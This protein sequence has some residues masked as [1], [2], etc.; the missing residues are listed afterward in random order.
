[1]HQ[2]QLTKSSRSEACLRQAYRFQKL[3]FCSRR[4]G[5]RHSF[6]FRHLDAVNGR[7]AVSQRDLQ[8]PRR[9]FRLLVDLGSADVPDLGHL[10]DK[11]WKNND[12]ICKMT[13]FHRF[14]GDGLLKH[15]R[16]DLPTSFSPNAYTKQ[17][18]NR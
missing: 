9:S 4:R 12:Q 11:A 8:H 3:D 16:D 7:L 6:D 1:M 10:Q 14:S 5:Q 2:R 15:Q 17:V 18:T 13:Q